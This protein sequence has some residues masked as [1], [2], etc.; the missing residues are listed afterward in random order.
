[1]KIDPECVPCLLKRIV[2]QSRLVEGQD[3]AA[4]LQAALKVV[5]E[6]YDGKVNSALLAT[7][8]HAEAYR[9]LGVRDPYHELKVRSDEVATSLVPELNRYLDEADDRLEA[10]VLGSIVGNVMDFGPEIAIQHPDE[11]FDVFHNLMDQGLD[12]NDVPRMKE[13]LLRSRKVLYLMDNCGEAVFD[14]PLVQEIQKLGVEV[15]GV[16]K[17]EPILTD[18]TRED[19]RRSGIDKVFDRMVDTGQFAIGL[20]L[21]RLGDEMEKEMQEY[22][23]IIAKGMANFESL[24]DTDVGP[25]VYLLRAKCRPVAHYLGVVKDQN[26]AVYRERADGRGDPHRPQPVTK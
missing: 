8:V 5:A 3:G 13:K 20:D 2:F 26:V 24:S 22:D 21:D 14:I 10:A 16:A 18:V 17:G 23:L 4:P 7:K 11:L 25:I 1:M 9:A 12:V 19:A 6:R 15:V